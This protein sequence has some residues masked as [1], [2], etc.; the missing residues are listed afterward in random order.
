M[1]QDRALTDQELLSIFNNPKAD[2]SLLSGDEQ[3]RLVGLTSHLDQ[4]QG[5]PVGRFIEGAAQN[6]NPVTAAEF[7]GKLFTSPLEAGKAVVE[8]SVAQLG[9]V[10]PAYREGRPLAALGHAAAAVPIV[11][12][13]IA[14]AVETMQGGNVAGGFGQMAGFA[15]P[16]VAGP[17]M[18]AGVSGFKAVAPEMAGQLANTLDAASAERLAG[19]MSPQVGAK[20]VNFGKQAVDI[21]PQLAREPGLNA[22]S[23]EG[24]HGGVAQKLQEASDALDAAA[25]ARLVSQQVKTG[26]LLAKMKEAIDA[27]TA[28]PVEGSAFPR[29]TKTPPAPTRGQ[30]LEGVTG[31]LTPSQVA[32]TQPIGEAVEPG[33]NASQIA[34]LRQIQQEVAALG[35]V[36]PYESIR[37]IRQAWDQV[38]RTKYLA[39]NAEDALTSTGKTTGAEKGTGALRDALA[40]A[41]ETTAA[42]N[43]R[44]HLFK[45]ADDILSITQE[46]ERVR[47]KVGRGLMRVATGAMI[48][49]MEG[50][51]T[52]GG[53]GAIAGAIANK[54]AEMAPTFQIMIA[55]RLAGVADALRNGDT[56][57]ANTLIQGTI[58]RFPTVKG[59]LKLTGKMAA[60]AGRLSESVPLAAQDDGR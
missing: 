55:R 14:N 27:L 24:L 46:R 49:S 25:D 39:S 6:L 23:R 1:P 35:P 38:A 29:N 36:A 31:E 22:F 58:Q 57:T 60:P 10:M 28:Q 33:P 5:N 41:D 56:A 17:A 21:A 4:P 30:Q 18:R 8:P 50:G 19:V 44:Y 16:F 42:A 54:A 9:Q 3:T 12:P 26:P 43:A 15:A 13:T 52:G 32:D 51:A 7:V 40:G 48:G 20:K 45:T 11:G 59:G 47:P 2:L 53:I 37:R 34:T